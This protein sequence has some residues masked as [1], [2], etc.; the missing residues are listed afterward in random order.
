MLAGLFYKHFKNEFSAGIG[1]V[2][3]TGIVGS[4]VAFPLS[5]FLLGSETGAFFFIPPF[6]IS[7]LVGAVLGIFTVKSLSGLGNGVLL[8]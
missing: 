7:S 6:L 3:G 4:L 1:E 2:I 5:R 8:K